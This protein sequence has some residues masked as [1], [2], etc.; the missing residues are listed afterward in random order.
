MVMDITQTVISLSKFMVLLVLLLCD[1]VRSSRQ[2]WGLFLT[3]IRA[4]LH[5]IVCRFQS[6][7][8]IF[9]AWK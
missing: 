8:L 3:E 1:E 7:I 4:K 6:P 2:Y 9:L 5:A